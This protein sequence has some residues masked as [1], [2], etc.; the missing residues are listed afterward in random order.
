[1]KSQKSNVRITLLVRYN[2]SIATDRKF[3]NFDSDCNVT[4]N[5]KTTIKVTLC[6]NSGYF[7]SKATIFQRNI[8][9]TLKQPIRHRGKFI[10]LLVSLFVLKNADPYYRS[11][12]TRKFFAGDK[13]RTI[14]RVEYRRHNNTFIGK[15]NTSIYSTT[16]TSDLHHKRTAAVEYG[17]LT[18]EAQT[19]SRQ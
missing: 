4:F 2:L 14:V 11:I 12:F 18:L 19:I 10:I 7:A 15:G 13:E 9:N 6:W 16:A 5:E 8:N 1:M 3:K 17:I